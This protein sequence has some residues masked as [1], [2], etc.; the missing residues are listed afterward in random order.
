MFIKPTSSRTAVTNKIT[1]HVSLV[2]QGNLEQI[3][4]IQTLGQDDIFVSKQ[5]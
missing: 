4:T 5:L 3:N 1:R 2:F